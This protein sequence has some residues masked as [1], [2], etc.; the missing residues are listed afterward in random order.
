M[1]SALYDSGWILSGT[2]NAAIPNRGFHELHVILAASGANGA[3]G[4][5]LAWAAG[6]ETPVPAGL[7]NN[8]PTIP[9]TPVITGALAVSDPA[10][11]SFTDYV[12]NAY[13]TASLTR[14]VPQEI[15]VVLTAGSASWARVIVE[16]A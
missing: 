12:L 5:A 8:P 15:N 16:G 9:V 6:A 7:R 4:S 10:A 1:P 3:T 2:I 13:N 11:N 14:F